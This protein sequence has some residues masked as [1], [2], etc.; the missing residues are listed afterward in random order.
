LRLGVDAEREEKSQRQRGNYQTGYYTR[1][2]DLKRQLHQ[3]LYCFNR[4]S[5]RRYQLNKG[6]LGFANNKRL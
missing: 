4:G 3:I 5:V 1:G 2:P 6:T